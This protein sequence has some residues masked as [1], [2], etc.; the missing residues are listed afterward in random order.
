MNWK[1]PLLLGGVLALAACESLPTKP[2]LNVIERDDGGIC[3]DR[4]DAAKLGHYILEL[5]AL[6]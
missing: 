1:L 3:L 4:E 6:Q 2:T 5:E